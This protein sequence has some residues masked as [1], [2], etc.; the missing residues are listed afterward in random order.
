[1]KVQ[2]EKDASNDEAAHNKYMCWCKT[3]EEAK[4]QAIADAAQDIADDQDP[5]A[6]AQ[7]TREKEF[8]A[9]QAEEADLKE[10]RG[11]LIEAVQTLSKVQLLQK[12]GSGWH[13]EATHAKTALLQLQNKVVQHGHP[14]FQSLMKR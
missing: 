11:L 4:N 8:V 12:Q 7:A 3:N 9:F 14:S 1:M 2:V 5:L 6:T 10:T 13:A